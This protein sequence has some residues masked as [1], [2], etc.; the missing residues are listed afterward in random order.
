MKL[1]IIIKNFKGKIVGIFNNSSED[2]D[3]NSPSDNVKVYNLAAIHGIESDI[4]SKFTR[5]KFIP[6][7]VNDNKSMGFI[8]KG[9]NYNFITAVDDNNL[10]HYRLIS[11]KSGF[12]GGTIN[13]MIFDTEDP[14]E[15]EN[16]FNNMFFPE[17]GKRL[18]DS[19]NTAFIDCSDTLS[20]DLNTD[21]SV[22]LLMS[23][24]NF[25]Y[26]EQT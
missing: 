15:V 6:T 26:D 9:T 5:V 16:Y 13:L 10:I 21:H 23:Y 2:G 24:F 11:R 25:E 17:S 18:G 8:Y 22:F 4:W 12:G 14:K 19:G 3:S 7:V 20:G 1:S